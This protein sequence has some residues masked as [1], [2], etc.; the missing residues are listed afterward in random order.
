VF[1]G[2]EGGRR[3]WGEGEEA[4]VVEES[5]WTREVSDNEEL[6]KN[7]EGGQ[8]KQKRWNESR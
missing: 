8:K 7:E 4:G 1:A 2:G 5:Y 6:L 3:G